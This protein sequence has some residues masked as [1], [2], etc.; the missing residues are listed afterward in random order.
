[1][2]NSIN[3]TWKHTA[4]FMKQRCHIN[5][6]GMP[7]VADVN[8]IFNQLKLPS[9][10]QGQPHL[11]HIVKATGRTMCVKVPLVTAAFLSFK[12]E[13]GLHKNCAWFF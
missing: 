6:Q 9:I 5:I 8:C 4:Q 7:A 2:T 3:H 11:E 13:L 10:F 1:M 12:Q